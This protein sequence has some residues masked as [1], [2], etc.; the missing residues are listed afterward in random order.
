MFI[1]AVKVALFK[2]SYGWGTVVFGT[3]TLAFTFPTMQLDIGQIFKWQE[4]KTQ[5]V[6][7]SFKVC[8]VH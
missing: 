6:E 4:R 7:C 1:S 2:Q 5:C 3:S 8:N